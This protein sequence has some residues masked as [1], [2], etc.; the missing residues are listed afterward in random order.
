[1]FG[2]VGQRFS[3]DVVD[4]DR[5]PLDW[6]CGYADGDI[7]R[8]RGAAS[9]SFQRRPE[10]SSRE[11]GW[12]NAP[13]QLTNIVQD[14]FEPGRHVGEESGQVCRDGRLLRSQLERQCHQPLLRAIM[15]VTLDPAPAV[16]TGCDDTG[17]GFD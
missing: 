4:G 13:G 9:K 16:I 15:E 3:D 8:K 10:S 2:D 6:T 7:D 5:D 1:M 12:M 11:R 14:L 17:A